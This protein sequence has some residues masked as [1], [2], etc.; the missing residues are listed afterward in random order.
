MHSPPQF[1]VYHDEGDRPSED[2]V[3]EFRLTYEG[4]LTSTRVWVEAQACPNCGHTPAAPKDGKAEHK[5]VIRKHFHSQLKQLWQVNPVLKRWVE[6]SNMKLAVLGRKP[7]TLSEIAD[8]FTDPHPFRW[9]PLATEDSQLICALDILYLRGDARGGLLNNADIDN[10][11]K[12]IIDALKMPKP[13]QLPGDASPTADE[14]PFFV[15]LE[16]D[17][18]VTRLSVDAD[19]LLSPTNPN[20][21]QTD[22][23]V[24]VS[25]KLWRHTS[26]PPANP[27]IGIW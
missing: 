1:I 18:L 3:L 2:D 8:N 23:R 27:M 14:D 16:D 15:L 6:Q 20:L 25:V 11:V 17:S 10:R 24:V 22:S 19:V 21:G 13:S 5:H 4:Q 7:P 26:L 12:T 9:L